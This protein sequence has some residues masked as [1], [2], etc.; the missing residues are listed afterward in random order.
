MSNVQRTA[1]SAFVGLVAAAVTAWLTWPTTNCIR[2][3]ELPADR[4]RKS[5]TSVLGLPTD[6]SLALAIAV[7]VGLVVAFL[8]SRFVW[9]RQVG[10]RRGTT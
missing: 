7:I 6:E 10:D 2:T 9:R 5:C 8:L 1:V 4:N 3:L